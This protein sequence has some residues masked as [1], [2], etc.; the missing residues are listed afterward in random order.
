MKRLLAIVRHPILYFWVRMESERMVLLH[1]ACTMLGGIEK[2]TVWDIDR[3]HEKMN[4]ALHI[5]H[6]DASIRKWFKDKRSVGAGLK[7]TLFLSR[8]K[9]L[10]VTRDDVRRLID[11]FNNAVN[12]LSKKNVTIDDVVAVHRIMA[13]SFEK[14]V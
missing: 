3:I 2:P 9:Q 12:V 8:F 10:N 5:F 1:A 4:M 6:N 11:L 7:W 13:M 14:Y